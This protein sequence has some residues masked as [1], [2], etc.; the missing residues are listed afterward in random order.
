MFT[1]NQKSRSWVIDAF[2]AVCML[3]I[4]AGM[5]FQSHK[6][7]EAEAE[8]E[9]LKTQLQKTESHLNGMDTEAFHDGET[10]FFLVRKTRIDNQHARLLGIKFT[11]PMNGAETA[12]VPGN[13]ATNYYIF[14]SL[15][16]I[17]W[18]SFQVKV[19]T[20]KGEE[21]LKVFP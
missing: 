4:I 19:V 9:K 8:V 13:E 18:A 15:K 1:E 10:T 20:T 16:P 5:L 11:N 7:N 14:K 17:P 21:L 6:R 2:V 3:V 12:L